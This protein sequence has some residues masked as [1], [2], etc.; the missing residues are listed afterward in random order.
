MTISAAWPSLYNPRAVSINPFSE[1]FL[2]FN[3]VLVGGIAFNT[4]T[5]ARARDALAL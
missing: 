5:Q 2:G 1:D 3:K 4:Q